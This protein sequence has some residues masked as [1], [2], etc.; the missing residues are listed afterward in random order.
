MEISDVDGKTMGM[1][2]LASLVGY[3]FY[4]FIQLKADVGVFGSN[5]EQVQ[6]EQRDLWNKFNKDQEAKFIFA[7][8]FYEFQ[9]Q[10]AN[11]KALAKEELLEFKVEYYKNLSNGK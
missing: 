9:I 1:A 6:S 4:G 11:D 10:E 2:A 3:V 7:T 5:Q 8:K